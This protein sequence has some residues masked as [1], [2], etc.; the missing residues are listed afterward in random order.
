MASRSLRALAIVA[1]V[2]APGCGQGSGAAPA[3]A[4]TPST[5]V[6]TP[7]AVIS[8]RGASASSVAEAGGR[9]W[10]THYEADLLSEVDPATETE[11]ATLD[12]GTQAGGITGARSDLWLARYSNRPEGARLTRVDLARRRVVQDT[13]HT[14]LC[15]EVAVTAGRVWALDRRGVVLGIDPDDGSVASRTPVV[16]DPAVHGGLM[17]DDR[18]LWVASDT[19]ALVRIDPT[20]AAVVASLDVGGGIPMAVAD[21]LVW[22]A[23]PHHVWAVDDSNAVRVRVPLEDTIEVLSLAVTAEALFVGARRPGYR[24]VLLRIDRA[25]QRLVAEADVSL[26]ARVLVAFGRVWAVDWDTNRLLAFDP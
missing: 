11:I 25:S 16:L 18:A 13:E 21:G 14:G 22:G 24:G 1:S 9:L 19:T 10:V 2:L 3:P 7:A 4:P 8:L 15:C 26:P 6:L 5:P 12:V 20:N 23:G 17:A